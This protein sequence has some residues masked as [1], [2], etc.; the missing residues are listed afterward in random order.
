MV[1]CDNICVW[2]HSDSE[3]EQY[4]NATPVHPTT[5]TVRNNTRI[6]FFQATKFWSNRLYRKRLILILHGIMFYIY[7]YIY[8]YTHTYV[9]H[10]D[11]F[12]LNIFPVL[13]LFWLLLLLISL[14]HSFQLF[15]CIRAWYK[16][17]LC[18]SVEGEFPGGKVVRI[19][20]FQCPGSSSVSGQETEILQAMGA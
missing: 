17:F 2:S 7:I 18:L 4:R 16:L 15:H 8:I 19:P 10:I 14:Y 5:E 9:L 1:A 11:F 3:P 12:S 20:G 13:D 6:L